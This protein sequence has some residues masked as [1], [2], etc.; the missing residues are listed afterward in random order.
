MWPVDR[1]EAGWGLSHQRRI[2]FE[3]EI[4]LFR[5]AVL[6]RQGAVQQIQPLPADGA[7]CLVEGRPIAHQDA[8][9][10]ATEGVLAF[11]FPHTQGTVA[12]SLAAMGR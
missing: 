8:Q 4:E 5:I 3:V 6:P 10:L 11:Q 2:T 9:G 1:S 7:A 12:H